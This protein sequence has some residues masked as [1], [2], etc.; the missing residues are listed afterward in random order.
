M[1]KNPIVMNNLKM[2]NNHK[3]ANFK[4]KLAFYIVTTTVCR[5][6]AEY[7]NTVFEM[8]VYPYF[9]SFQGKFYKN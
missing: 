3:T 5:K 1:I 6:N 9:Y 7:C 4:H 2:N 8:S